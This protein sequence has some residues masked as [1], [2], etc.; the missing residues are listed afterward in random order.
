MNE[1]LSTHLPAFLLGVIA[2]ALVNCLWLTH[3]RE[4]PDSEWLDPHELH[5]D[6][7]PETGEHTPA[8]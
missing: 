6:I 2:T 8:E 3:P 7:N 5:D 1:Y 4:I